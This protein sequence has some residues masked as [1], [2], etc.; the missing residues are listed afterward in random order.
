MET[1]YST[2][3]RGLYVEGSGSTF[4]RA[5]YWQ[6]SEGG[7]AEG[8]DWIEID[9]WDEFEIHLGNFTPV[10][11][12][13]LRRAKASGELGPRLRAWVWTNWSADILEALTESGEEW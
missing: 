1:T 12:R 13:D 3:Y 10:R 8:I 11:R 4:V 7:Y 5:T 6:P 9:D 2:Y